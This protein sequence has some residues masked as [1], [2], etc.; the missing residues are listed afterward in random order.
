MADDEMDMSQLLIFIKWLLK[1]KCT[2]MDLQAETNIG[3]I[4]KS[5]FI[6]ENRVE[7]CFSLHVVTCINLQ[8]GNKWSFWLFYSS[9]SNNHMPP[10]NFQIKTFY[11]RASHITENIGFQT[12]RLILQKDHLTY[13]S[14]SKPECTEMATVSS[15]EK[16]PTAF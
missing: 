11:F 16:W 2:K 12:I 8:Y 5:C 15:E 1:V 10:N 13:S 6:C 3:H 14:R 7:I 4:I 9:K